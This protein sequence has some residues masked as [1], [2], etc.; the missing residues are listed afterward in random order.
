MTFTKSFLLG[1]SAAL[2]GVAAAQAADLPSRKA[3]PVEYVRVCDAYGRGFFYIPGTDTCIRIGGRVRADYAFSERGN[4]FN[5]GTINRTTGVLTNTV[6]SLGAVQS[7]HG[8]EGRGRISFDTR[9]QTAWGVVQ[10]TATLRMS[11]ST[12]TLQATNGNPTSDTGSTGSTLE[13]AY[14]RF[15]GFT[16]G[17]ARDN[18][19]YMPSRMYGAG[20]WGSFANGA[21]Q[22]AYTHSFGGGLSATVAIQDRGYTTNGGQAS[23]WFNGGVLVGAP[24][25]ITSNYE[26]LPQ[27]NARIDWQQSWGDLSL[28]G[29]IGQANGVTSATSSA[30][31]VNKTVWAVGAG[32]KFN[33][34]MI[35]AGD[36][37][38]LTAAYADG[39]TEYT[40]NWTYFKSSDTRRNVNGFVVNHP[41]W[42]YFAAPNRIET[43]KSWN[44]AALFDHFWTPQWRSTLM[45]SYGQV[46][47]P[48]SADLAPFSSTVGGDAKMWNVAHQIA[49]LPTRDFEI[50]FELI[51]SRVS[52]DVRRTG[53]GGGALFCGT[54]NL[55]SCVTRESTDGITGRLRVERNF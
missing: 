33:L 20:H 36:A 13:S 25:V 44:V 1:S 10:A 16:F 54:G 45:G 22:L 37:L 47:M 5:A 51:Y 18:F 24:T 38:W 40:T 50:G 17:I 12:G 53:V 43:V 15:A 32:A 4:V 19:A 30:F 23:S 42:V 35:S 28:S 11:R 2:M 6:S 8:F 39:M 55:A 27:F 31:D 9:T 34:P 3:A 29:A 21:M 52:Q 7:T 26:G 14:V 49:W 46:M 48:G 41:S